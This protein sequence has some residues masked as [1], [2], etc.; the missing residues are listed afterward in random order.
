MRL[1][2]AVTTI[3]LAVSA[4]GP[5][6]AETIGFLVPGTLS[7]EARREV[8]FEQADLRISDKRIDATHGVRRAEDPDFATS[9]PVV[10]GQ[11]YFV[12]NATGREHRLIVRTFI[13]GQMWVD[14]APEDGS[15]RKANP[16][17]Y[18]VERSAL[19]GHPLGA[20]YP[21][22]QLR[23]DG[24][25][26]FG[27][28]SGAYRQGNQSVTLE[29]HYAQWGAADVGVD[30]KLTFSFKRGGGRM[31]LVLAPVPPDGSGSSLT[32]AR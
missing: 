29:G 7:T 24:T 30:G 8:L 10:I 17:R 32:A 31:T 5:A 6:F 26:R 14:L 19:N 15:T 16:G 28:A 20:V 23:A 3:L 4:T 22:L 2:L 12:R 11:T 21:E 1:R 27:G 18:R 25:F 9:A 13:E